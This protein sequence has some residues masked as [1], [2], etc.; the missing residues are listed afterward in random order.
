[1]DRCDYAGCSSPVYGRL[2]SPEGARLAS[3]CSQHAK[4]VCDAALAIVESATTRKD[5][6]ALQNMA[7][8]VVMDVDPHFWHRYPELTQEVIDVVARALRSERAASEGRIQ[9]LTKG[10]RSCVDVLDWLN[11]L[12]GLGLDKHGEI[13]RAANDGRTILAEDATPENVHG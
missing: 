3:Y 6:D 10:L 1:M 4:A 5:P 2:V 11:R 8:R 13:T 12:G 9:Q 7:E